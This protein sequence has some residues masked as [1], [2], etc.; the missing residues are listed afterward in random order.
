MNA[1]L[2]IPPTSIVQNA[3]MARSILLVFALLGMTAAGCSTGTSS[4]ASSDGADLKR[5]SVLQVSMPPLIRK[6]VKR[7]AILHPT[8]SQ[9]PCV[10]RQFEK[11]MTEQLE[12]TV[13]G[14]SRLHP[15]IELV[16]RRNLDV[17]LKEL[18][19]QASGLVR[20]SDFVGIGRMIGA[21]HVLSYE[22]A[23]T[24]QEVIGRLKTEGGSVRASISGKIINVQ[25]G[26]VVYHDTFEQSVFLPTPPRPQY[27]INPEPD[28]EWAARKSLYS[29]KVS[30]FTA[31]STYRPSGIVWDE[32]YNGPGGKVY[33]VLTGSPADRIDIRV[34]DLITRRDGIPISSSKEAEIPKRGNVSLTVVRE[35]VTRD[36]VLNMGD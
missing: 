33:L 25:T 30:L 12:R 26:A 13:F 8:M 35:G 24:P 31:F 3:L 15:P 29:L 36:Y 20:D 27:W 18:Q 5:Y 11:T 1:T 28:L 32:A 34:G 7:L 22:I 6:Q 14:I 17:A 2:R 16:E 23:C 19:I 21:D 9:A 10:S 4:R